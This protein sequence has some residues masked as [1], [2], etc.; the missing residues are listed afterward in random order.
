MSELRDL[1]QEIGIRLSPILL[2]L[3]DYVQQKTYVE[4]FCPLFVNHS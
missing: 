2:E 4:Q 1:Q 3:I